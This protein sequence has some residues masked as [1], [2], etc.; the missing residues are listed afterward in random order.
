M[1]NNKTKKNSLFYTGL[2]LIFASNLQAA[3]ILAVDL[4][5]QDSGTI[6]DSSNT[7]TFEFDQQQP[8]GTGELKPFVRIQ[9]N[10]T[11][12]GYNTTQPN[13]GALP[14]EEKFGV[15]THDL[16]FSD[17]E[18]FD[19]EY[20]F[21]LDIGEPVNGSNSLLSLDGLKLFS[22][23]TPGQNSNSIDSNG[24][25]DGILGT[26]LW[27]MD[28]LL[29]NYVLL[30]ANRD[31]KPGN[32]VSD[33]LLKVPTSVFDGVVATDNIILWSRFGLQESSTSGSGSFG[34]FE[35]WAQLVSKSTNPP[36]PEPDPVPEPTSLM[37]L[38][39]GLLGFVGA[40]RKKS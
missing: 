2:A 4:T 34:T 39:L 28:D 25:A 18:V 22:T 35:E 31:G 29:D 16:L 19:D 12:Q 24:D 27:D 23:T 11:E 30:D 3:P 1:I 13:A 26:L 38:G 20:L 36:T 32:G 14:F 8:S 10:G 9:K 21:I 40:R 7:L 6:A 33:M 37:L 17:L 15:W 5:Q